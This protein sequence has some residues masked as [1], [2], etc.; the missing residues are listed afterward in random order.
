M[1]RRIGAGHWPGRVSKT[2][3]FNPALSLVLALLPRENGIVPGP[4]A[5]SRRSSTLHWARS[6]D[7]LAP[8]VGQIFGH[9]D[10]VLNQDASPGDDSP[11][12]QVVVADDF[13][14]RL[15]ASLDRPVVHFLRLNVSMKFFLL[16]FQ[17]HGHRGGALYAPEKIEVIAE[18][19]TLI[20]PG[21]GTVKAVLPFKS[22]R[23]VLHRAGRFRLG[24]PVPL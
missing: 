14:G 10:A 24:P 2:P 1:G 3:P 4:T 18:P 9:D 20:E 22:N 7:S 17:A 16:V 13:E 8:E 11:A 21:H 12:I 5:Q 23:S 6:G 19:L 15:A